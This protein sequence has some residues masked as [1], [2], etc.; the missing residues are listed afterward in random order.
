MLYFKMF[1][2]L[3]SLVVYKLLILVSSVC[4]FFFKFDKTL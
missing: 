4:L 1:E 2:L 3:N